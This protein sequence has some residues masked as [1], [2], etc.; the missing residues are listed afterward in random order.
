[1]REQ[2]REQL[3]T[4]ITRKEFLR[5]LMAAML[6]LFGLNNF[7]SMLH[8]ANK[9]IVERRPADSGADGFGSRRFGV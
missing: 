5:Y 8:G 3:N 9:I 1:M 7:L 6:M 2:L 4:E